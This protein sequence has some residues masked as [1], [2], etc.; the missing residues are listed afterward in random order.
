MV[1]LVDLM[2]MNVYK[3]TGDN[4]PGRIDRLAGAFLQIAPNHPANGNSRSF[5]MSSAHLPVRYSTSARKVPL[6]PGLSYSAG[7]RGAV[8][9]V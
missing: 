2:N 1:E 5:P 6:M 4:Q 8:C 7:R 9:H 3:A